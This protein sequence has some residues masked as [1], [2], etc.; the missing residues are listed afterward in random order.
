MSEFDKPLSKFRRHR[1]PER[2]KKEE[3]KMKRSQSPK[4]IHERY[5]ISVNELFVDVNI[6]PNKTRRI[7]I[8]K[9]DDPVVLV[10]NFA[11]AFHLTKD[12][13]LMLQKLLESNIKKH[14]TDKYI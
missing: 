5:P 8:K 1:S 6:G 3:N 12:M 2:V 4:A 10:E 9:G 7:A 13:K 11:K 14:F